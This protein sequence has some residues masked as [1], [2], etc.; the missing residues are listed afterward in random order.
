[1]QDQDLLINCCMKDVEKNAEDDQGLDNYSSNLILVI[2]MNMVELK[3]SEPHVHC[4]FP[5]H[6]IDWL[7]FITT[8]EKC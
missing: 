3:Q 6:P 7:E 2:Q 8:M 5:F 1:M 4:H